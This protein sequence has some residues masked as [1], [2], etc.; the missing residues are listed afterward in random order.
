MSSDHTQSKHNHTPQY[1]WYKRSNCSDFKRLQDTKVKRN[2]K[3]TKY[4]FV[5]IIYCIWRGNPIVKNSK[6]IKYSIFTTYLYFYVFSLIFEVRRENA[7]RKIMSS[8]SLEQTTPVGTVDSSAP[9]N[10]D[11][12]R[13]N[14]EMSSSNMPSAQKERSLA[15]LAAMQF[16]AGGC[17]GARWVWF[18]VGWIQKILHCSLHDNISH[19]CCLWPWSVSWPWL[20][21]YLQGQDHSAHIAKISDWV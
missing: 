2:R 17:A 13:V 19:D 1:R 9:L 5:K 6:A 21:S 12:P 4:S 8:P 16:A 15:T 10:W 20:R 14:A 11:D 18:N 3:R 7:F